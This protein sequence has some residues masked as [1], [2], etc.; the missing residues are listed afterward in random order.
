M[1]PVSDDELLE[2][3]RETVRRNALDE[4]GVYLQVTRGAADRDFVWPKDATPGC[5]RE[6]RQR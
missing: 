6:P 3:H 4:G 2:I 5:K 1:L